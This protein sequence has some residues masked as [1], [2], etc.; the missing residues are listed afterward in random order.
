VPPDYAE[1]IRML[2]GRLGLTQTQL[3]ESVGVSV[4][5]G[6]SGGN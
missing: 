1:R 3:A 2:R 6:N 5:T 4:A